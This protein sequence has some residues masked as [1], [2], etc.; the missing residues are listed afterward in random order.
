M[1]T[2]RVQLVEMLAVAAATAAAFWIADGPTA[3][4]FPAALIGGFSLLV[5]FGRTRSDTLDVM[6]G[7]G[8]ERSRTLYTRS[9]ALTGSVL[10]LV[11]PGWWL[12]TVA[13]GEP[14]ET[15]T[16]VCALFGVTFIVATLFVAKRG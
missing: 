1:N 3:A 8:D 13:T 16:L 7:I 15:L 4:I 9:L 2:P 14:D 10:S 6:S 12:V 11:L 5:Y